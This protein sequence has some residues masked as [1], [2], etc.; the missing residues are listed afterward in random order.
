MAK[1]QIW[2]GRGHKIVFD[3]LHYAAPWRYMHCS[4]GISIYWIELNTRRCSQLLSCQWREVV[5]C[6][7]S[8]KRKH[9]HSHST[10]HHWR[11]FCVVQLF[12]T[13]FFSLN[14]HIFDPF[15]TSR[16][17]CQWKHHRRLA[18]KHIFP[19]ISS[20]QFGTKRRSA[21]EKETIEVHK[22]CKR[23][24]REAHKKE[25]KNYVKKNSLLGH[26]YNQ[27]LFILQFSDTL[28]RR[29]KRMVLLWWFVSI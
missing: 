20:L 4:Y 2:F 9:F 18:I 1:G 6:K 7:I 19:L 23:A 16:S 17:H 22:S 10:S 15:T 28:F 21:K 8:R 12:V 25:E 24:E 14:D 13:V 11:I 3:G 5:K 26:Y 27:F 29:G